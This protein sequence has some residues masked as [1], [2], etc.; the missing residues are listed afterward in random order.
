MGWWVVWSLLFWEGGTLKPRS[1]ERKFSWGLDID[2]RDSEDPFYDI[3]GVRMR[4]DVCRKC[5]QIM[6]GLISYDGFITDSRERR[7]ERVGN[8]LGLLLEAIISCWL[9][10]SLA[11]MGFPFS[12]FVTYFVSV[13]DVISYRAPEVG[14]E[15]HTYQLTM[16]RT[17]DMRRK[18]VLCRLAE[19]LTSRRTRAISRHP[20]P[21]IKEYQFDV[22]YCG[23]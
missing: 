16:L 15:V 2:Q 3:V 9:V 6:N 13:R 11:H 20:V 23:A 18:N 5:T 14:R 21:Q 1:S 4:E 22:S 19:I 7:G 17:M 12:L 8:E 10:L